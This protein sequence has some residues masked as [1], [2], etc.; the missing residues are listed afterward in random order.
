ML[1]LHVAHSSPLST[2]KQIWY[3]MMSFFDLGGPDG[4]PKYFHL[5]FFHC[6][7]HSNTALAGIQEL[8]WTSSVVLAIRAVTKVVIL[9]PVF[10]LLWGLQVL[11]ISF[12]WAMWLA[13]HTQCLQNLSDFLQIPSATC[14]IFC[15]LPTSQIWHRVTA[16]LQLISLVESLTVI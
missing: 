7:I 15:I 1:A 10:Q 9:F 11:Q 3:V 2:A 4:L 16:A 8:I 12:F 14:R 5:H 6:L 13:S